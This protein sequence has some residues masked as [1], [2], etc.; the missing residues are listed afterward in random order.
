MFNQDLMLSLYQIAKEASGILMSY[1]KQEYQVWQKNDQ[2]MVTEADL[3]VN[4][5]ICERIK[6]ITPSIP[7]ISEEGDNHQ[8]DISD[9]FWLVDPL[10][11]TKGF[12]SKNDQFAISIGLINKRRPKL[13]LIYIPVSNVAYFGEVGYGVYKIDCQKNITPIKVSPINNTHIVIVGSK[14]KPLSPTADYLSNIC[15]NKVV[16]MASAIKFCE[17]VEGRATLYPRFGPTME[18]DTAAGHAMLLAIGGEIYNIDGSKLKYG[19]PKYLN[20]DF[21]ATTYQHFIP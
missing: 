9:S 2:S 15:Y 1:Y 21:I 8:N 16:H 11:G 10:D 14:Y 19:K 3:A 20:G 18:W 5:L 6:D 4:E 12:I 17:M 13:G 7:I